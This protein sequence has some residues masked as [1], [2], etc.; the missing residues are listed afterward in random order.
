MRCTNK[1]NRQLW[2]KHAIIIGRAPNNAQSMSRPRTCTLMKLTRCK[3]IRD[4]PWVQSRRST[5]TQHV[6]RTWLPQSNKH[7]DVEQ[8]NIAKPSPLLCTKH[9]MSSAMRPPKH[10]L[11]ASTLKNRPLVHT[12]IQEQHNMST[13]CGAP[14]H[15]TGDCGASKHSLNVEPQAMH[16]A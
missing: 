14:T 15:Q 2:S 11:A 8:A 7:A 13:T 5:R 12:D 1:P 3:H 9:D 16:K 10:S 6:S 4:G